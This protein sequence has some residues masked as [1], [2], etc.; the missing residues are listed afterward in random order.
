MVALVTQDL[1]ALPRARV[2]DSAPGD[3]P[4]VIDSWRESWRVGSRNRRLPRPAYNGLFDEL[5]VRG[6]FALPE[7]RVMV[8]C[9]DQAE[10]V[11]LGWVCYEPGSIP[12]VH[13]AVVLGERAVSMRRRGIFTTLLAAIGVRDAMV[14]TFRPPDHR[15]WWD[16][17]KRDLEGDLVKA[18]KQ[19]GIT[20]HY[21]SVRDYLRG[22]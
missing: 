20:A 10:D 5:V 12:T 2:R 17:K 18:G 1:P 6:V 8:S 21:H 15:H 3:L 13:Y 22:V 16:R 7:T 14:Y 4:Y 9:D 19:H 11:V